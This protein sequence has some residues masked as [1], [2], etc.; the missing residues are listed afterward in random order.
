MLG[1]GQFDPDNHTHRRWDLL[2][3][4]DT[5]DQ[6]G[7]TGAVENYC[8]VRPMGVGGQPTLPAQL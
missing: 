2:S 5:S 6:S 4:G 3:R 1:G 7:W 8:N